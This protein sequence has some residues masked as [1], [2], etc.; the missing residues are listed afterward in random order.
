[1]AFFADL[2][3]P[4]TLPKLAQLFESDTLPEDVD[5]EESLLWYGEVAV[6]II[7]EH[8]ERGL[9]YLLSS[10]PKCD[11]RRLDG[12]LLALC[13]LPPDTLNRKRAILVDLLLSC[14]HDSRE[15]IVAEAI[16][17]LRYFDGQDILA[18]VLP[19]VNH[20]S[21]FVQGAALYFLSKCHFP[22]AKPFLFAALESPSPIIRQVAIDELE[23]APCVE[24]LPEI[25]KL[26]SD[27]HP[28]VRQAAQTA[29]ENLEEIANQTPTRE[30]N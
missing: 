27:E 3:K 25:R 30:E 11:E 16:R 17:T 15:L 23:E 26:L 8:S 13:F 18:H 19:F 22:I 14:L 7:E 9:E 6:K 4:M 1:M 28:D 20:P 2:G 21:P 12:V 5:P 29:V 24:A 10:V